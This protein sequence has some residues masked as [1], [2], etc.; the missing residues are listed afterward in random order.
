MLLLDVV[1]ACGLFGS[2]AFGSASEHPGGW[3]VEWSAAACA[4]DAGGEPLLCR[5]G[6][7]RRLFGLAGG[8]GQASGR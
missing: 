6:Q 8:H 1:T 7:E 2:A 3:V 4:W 5:V